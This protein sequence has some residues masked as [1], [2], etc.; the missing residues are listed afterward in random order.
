MKKLLS[1]ILTLVIF[2]VPST[3]AFAHETSEN[4]TVCQEQNVIRNTLDIEILEDELN[5]FIAQNPNSTEAEQDAHLIEFIN[6]GGLNRPATRGVGD[7]IPGY[8]DL[9]EKER[10]LALKHPVEAVKVYNASKT[11]TSQ[12]IEVYGQ[13]GY[14]DNSDAFRHCLWNALMKQSMDVESAEEWATAHEYKSTGIDKD[15]DLHNNMIGRGIDVDD[16]SESEIVTA[17]KTEVKNGNCVRIVDDELVAT[18]DSG[19][20]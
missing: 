7:Y 12:T 3:V 5:K 10:E 18:D 11:A 19:M 17:V 6:N 2:L 4:V 1:F 16:K 8:K 13:N 15:M 20:K 14:Q 9:N